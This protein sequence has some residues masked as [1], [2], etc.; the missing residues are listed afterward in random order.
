LYKKLN[1][2]NKPWFNK[3]LFFFIGSLNFDSI[4]QGLLLH[5]KLVN[6]YCDHYKFN[7]LF[8]GTAHQINLIPEHSTQ[9]FKL[10]V[11]PDGPDVL[12]NSG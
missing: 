11:P 12:I 4:E 8:P 2:V 10:Q 5:L 3:A 1:D 9:I 7:Y 6:H